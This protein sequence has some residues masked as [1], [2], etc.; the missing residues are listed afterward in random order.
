MDFN[1]VFIGNPQKWGITNHEVLICVITVAPKLPT[2]HV[3]R[4]ARK[5]ASG[6]FRT[7]ET[8]L[9]LK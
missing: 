9:I 1:F 2:N 3:R 7:L 8:K 6:F 5:S 4:F